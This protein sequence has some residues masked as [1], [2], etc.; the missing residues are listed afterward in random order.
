M[1]NDSKAHAEDR[2][3]TTHWTWRCG[4]GAYTEPLPPYS[5]AP[6]IER[7]YTGYQ[8]RQVNTS[9]A[10]NLIYNGVPLVMVAQSLWQNNS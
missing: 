1:Y 2:T 9:P 7:H 3:Y 5:T 8:K 4:A 6:D 10:T